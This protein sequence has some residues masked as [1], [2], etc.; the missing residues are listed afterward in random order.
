MAETKSE[1]APVQKQAKAT[2]SRKAI[3]A[4]RLAAAQNAG[5]LTPKIRRGL[6]RLAANLAKGDK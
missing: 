4:R 5:V 3:L 2:S 6:D 1:A